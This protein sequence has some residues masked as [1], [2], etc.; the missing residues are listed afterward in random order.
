[1]DLQSLSSNLLLVGFAL[2]SICCLYLLYSNFTKVREIEDLKH[3][4]EDLK[5]IF[6]N[7]QKHNDETYSNIMNILVEKDSH[8]NHRLSES[9]S[10]NIQQKEINNTTSTKLINI[11]LMKSSELNLENLEFNNSLNNK[12]I[13]IDLLEL[14][15]MDDLDD[16]LDDELNNND[17]DEELN[18]DL[19][20]ELNNDLNDSSKLNIED[21]IDIKDIPITEDNI[22]D[23]IDLSKNINNEICDDTISITTDPMISDLDLNEIMEG[24][25]NKDENENED[26][27]KNEDEDEDDNEN[28]NENENEDVD[29]NE[30]KD[31]DNEL[32]NLDLDLDNLEVDLDINNEFNLNITKQ[33]NIDN[34]ATLSD[35]IINQST[36]NVESNN[37][38]KNIKM[39]LEIETIELDKLLSGEIKKIE[40]NNTNELDL[41]A[42]SIKQLKELAKVHNIKIYGNKKDLI[43]ALSA[44]S[45]IK[46]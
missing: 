20:D 12:S 5:N 3:K 7:Q 32:D 15:D 17:L 26:D 13:N 46:L 16:D 10:N 33:V 1:M 31:E 14:D 25:H 30:N 11:D 8:V 2:V 36:I 40:I 9:A 35:T 38:I 24:N 42:M 27:N 45:D 41:N 28:E 34:L 19:V 6:F 4:V 23:I 18:N 22:F 21:S 44:L 43:S 29:D 39:D 37:D